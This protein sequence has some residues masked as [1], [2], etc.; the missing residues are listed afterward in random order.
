MFYSTFTLL[1]R[2]KWTFSEIVRFQT[3]LNNSTRESKQE[4]HKVIAYPI[5]ALTEELSG[6][7]TAD[8]LFEPLLSFLLVS[9]SPNGI[10]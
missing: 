9:L 3:L 10:H 2:R 6:A 7:G 5:I 1:C 8:T 4:I